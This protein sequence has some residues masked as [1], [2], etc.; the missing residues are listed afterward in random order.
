MLET[1]APALGA[2]RYHSPG[3]WDSAVT[4]APPQF[5]EIHS[6]LSTVI[7]LVGSPPLVSWGVLARLLL[8]GSFQRMGYK[9]N[10]ATRE[11]FKE[12]LAVALDVQHSWVRGLRASERGAVE[13]LWQWA[14]E[15]GGLADSWSTLHLDYSSTATVHIGGGEASSRGSCVEGALR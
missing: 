13:C 5:K 6:L 2:F 4:E 3:F 12:T 11:T 14:M 8:D 10:A 15:P 1:L 7:V 9:L